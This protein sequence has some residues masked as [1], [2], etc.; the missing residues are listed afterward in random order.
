M[1]ASGRGMTA[2]KLERR[3]KTRGM[4]KDIT[5]QLASSLQG[6]WV[7]GKSTRAR[8]RLTSECTRAHRTDLSH[9][10][11]QHGSP[12]RE[13]AGMQR[14]AHPGNV[15]EDTECGV[16]GAEASL[17]PLTTLARR[18][19]G[20]IKRTGPLEAVPATP[21]GLCIRGLLRDCTAWT[22]GRSAWRG[23]GLAC[24]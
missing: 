13:S 3:A 15:S 20:K 21:A 24:T 17:L 14:A 11:V 6:S 9:P 2:E 8:L 23:R 12:S 1:C 19:S 10:R 5:K 7:P 16:H 4:V 22:L 18:S